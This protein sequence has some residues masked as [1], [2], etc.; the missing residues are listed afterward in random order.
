MDEILSS[1]FNY[2]K[3]KYLLYELKKNVTIFIKLFKSNGYELDDFDKMLEENKKTIN[4]IKRRRNEVYLKIIKYFYIRYIEELNSQNLID[5]DDMII[6]A[7]KCVKENGMYKEYKYIII[8]EYQDTSYIRYKLINEIRKSLNSK[9]LAVGDDFQS[10]YRFTGCD[11]DIFLKFNEYYGYTKVL[12]IENTYRNSKELID[13]AGKFIMK[14]KYQ[15]KKNLNSNKSIKKPI[16]IFY[17][18]DM[19]KDFIK[20]LKYI[21]KVNK[22]NI[23][24][25]GRNNID[26]NKYLS[27]DLKLNGD[28][29]IIKD[30]EINIKYL[31]IHKSKGLEEDNIV[32]INLEDNKLGFPSKIQNDDIISFVLKNKE[33]YPYEEERRLFY[34][35]L[36]RTKNNVYIF[37]NKKNESIFLKEIKSDSNNYIEVIDKENM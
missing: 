15:I 9:I 6:N 23:L 8:D 20:L 12:K 37:S 17:Y 3:D 35:A 25:L 31:T 5:F 13:V 4:K 21:Y 18:K 16:K 10:I 28:K 34:V 22:S 2:I 19:K 27:E 1:E 24:V 14:N 30:S 26:I 33:L 11:L 29:L 7:T 36:T 32:I